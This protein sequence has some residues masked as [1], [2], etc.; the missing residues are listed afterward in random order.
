MPLAGRL[1]RGGDG[2]SAAISVDRFGRALWEVSHKRDNSHQRLSEPGWVP[3]SGPVPPAFPPKSTGFHFCCK[4][5]HAAR[6]ESLLALLNAGFFVGRCSLEEM[7]RGHVGIV[8]RRC[9]PQG[10]AWHGA[11]ANPGWH[12]AV[13]SSV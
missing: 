4:P 3:R 8:P 7:A 13:F 2:L 5:V 12:K 1:P 9:H 10:R 11:G 6:A